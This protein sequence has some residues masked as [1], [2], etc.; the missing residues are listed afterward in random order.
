MS[1]TTVFG[2]YYVNIRARNQR[3][4][5]IWTSERAASTL[6]YARWLTRSKFDGKMER[7]SGEMECEEKGNSKRKVNKMDTGRILFDFLL[8]IF[9]FGFSWIPIYRNSRKVIRN[10]MF[11][12]ILDSSFFSVLLRSFLH[13]RSTLS[14][15]N[16][17]TSLFSDDK[18]D[19]FIYYFVWFLILLV[20]CIFLECS[21]FAQW[22]V[23]RG[24]ACVTHCL[25]SNPLR[26][27]TTR[28]QS[29]YKYGITTI[30]IL[31]RPRTR[32][33]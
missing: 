19:L 33:R 11:S 13:R 26:H 8:L 18:F 9:L 2:V 21:L 22:N 14:E 3:S 29:G 27:P 28:S 24:G 1:E 4:S 25:C 30:W 23:W 16:T 7:K 32:W 12:F 15:L 20:G 6:T 10:V 5:W 31:P 17:K